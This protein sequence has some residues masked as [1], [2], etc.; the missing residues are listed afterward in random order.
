MSSP[1]PVLPIRQPALTEGPIVRFLQL[2]EGGLAPRRADRSVGG[3]LPGRAMRYCEPVSAASALGWYV[4]LP[5]R[6]QLLWDGHEIFWRIQDMAEFA[7]LRSVHYPGFGE[8]FDAAAPADVKSYAPSFLAASVQAG[9]VQVWPGALARTASAWSLLVR[10]VANLNRPSGYEVFEGIIETDGW[11]GPLFTN[12]RL[13]RTGVPVEFDDDIPFLQV[14]PIRKSDYSDKHLNRFEVVPGL[15]G[16]T[17]EDWE[18]YRKTV[19][20]PNA[21]TQRRRGAYAAEV[22]KRAAGGATEPGD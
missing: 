21:S 13:T 4:F 8:V 12:I 22:R 1:F 16:L 3:T 15:A 5:R 9:M 7:P 2:V 6:F 10:P 17:A 20:E 11:L 18:D 14:Q 19:V